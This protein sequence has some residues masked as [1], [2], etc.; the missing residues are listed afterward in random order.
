M[1][2]DPAGQHASTDW[3][4]AA[5][6]GGRALVIFSPRTG[7]TH[8][9]RVHAAEGIGIPILG[10]PVYGSGGGPTLLHALA[11]R[12]PREKRPA[13]EAHAPLPEIFRA[14]GFDAADL[15]PHDDH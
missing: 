2:P 11:L 6:R 13:V 14:A 4:V 3:R 9:I 10:D 15:E 1:V 8:Q 12:V 7:R 5:A